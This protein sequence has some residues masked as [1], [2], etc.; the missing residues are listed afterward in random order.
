M[1]SGD[2][3]CYVDRQRAMGFKYRVQNGLL[4]NFATFAEAQDDDF[5]RTER[6]LDWAALAPSRAQR[7]NRLLT[8]RRFA[9]AMQA[10]DERYQIPPVDA[11]GRAP[12]AWQGTTGTAVTPVEGN[13]DDTASVARST[14]RAAMVRTLPQYSW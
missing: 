2:I 9:W 13:H 6:V 10:E 8:V 3:K 5:V 11:F 12:C 7:R 4:L 1:L 14:R